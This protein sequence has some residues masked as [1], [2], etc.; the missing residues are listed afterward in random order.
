MTCSVF[1]VVLVPVVLQQHPDN[2]QLLHGGGVQE[3]GVLGVRRGD[4]RAL[5][6][7]LHDQPLYGAPHGGRFHRARLRRVRH[8]HAEVGVWRECYG[9][10]LAIC[11]SSF[12]RCCSPFPSCS[13]SP[14]P[15]CLVATV[16]V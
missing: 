4:G 12:T 9:V 13:C 15:V 3:G 5:P 6:R 10:V 2:L 7:L 11:C 14:R 8:A 16:D 1:D